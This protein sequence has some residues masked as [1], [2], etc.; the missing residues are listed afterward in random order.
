MKCTEHF[1]EGVQQRSKEE[2]ETQKKTSTEE[3]ELE[4]IRASQWVT[5]N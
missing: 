3:L 5:V 2:G 1:K 4:S